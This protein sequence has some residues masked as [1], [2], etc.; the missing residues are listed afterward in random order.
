MQ[1]GEIIVLVVFKWK[2]EPL[3]K[4]IWWRTLP[5]TVKLEFQR[6]G[7]HWVIIWWE[8]NLYIDL[9][10]IDLYYIYHTGDSEGDHNVIIIFGA[11]SNILDLWSWEFYDAVREWCPD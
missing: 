6:G 7:I 2:E 4:V 9:K 8:K 11:L 5:G 1:I 3:H 10:V